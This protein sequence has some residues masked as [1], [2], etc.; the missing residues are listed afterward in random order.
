[1]SRTSAFLSNPNACLLS[2]FKSVFFASTLGLLLA[3]A[4]GPRFL[5]KA[6]EIDPAALYRV[7]S[8]DK[9][10]RI[11]YENDFFTQTDRDYTQGINLEITHPIFRKSQ[12]DF[13][14]LKT[15]GRHYTGISIEL[16]GYTPKNIGV[17]EIQ[18]GDH[19]YA[20][21]LNLRSFHIS[22]DTSRKLRLVSH[23]GF[24]IM[25]PAGGGDEIQTAVHKRFENTLP[26]GWGNQIANEFLLNYGVD[27][28]RPIIAFQP[29]F[30]LT[31]NGSLVLGTPFTRAGLGVTLL[32]GRFQS[33]FS[34]RPPLRG[35]RFFLYYQPQTL[36]FLYD[37]TLQ[38]GLLNP[39]SPYTIS[40]ADIKQIRFQH[41]TG[42]VFE[43]RHF[44]LEG[45]VSQ[46]SSAYLRNKPHAWGGIHLGVGF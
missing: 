42:F 39:T 36:A 40:G 23:F 32:T 20:A 35:V 37:A 18:F 46:Q 15:K 3:I 31:G 6:Q 33:P 45:S 11:S 44:R 10:V 28:Q 14:L 38:G 24:G 2:S 12:L 43:Y 41:T 26:L 34:G 9:S 4:P 25:G 29:G 16:D 17:R 22:E 13:L 5:L 7:R 19:P 30:L 8:L 21:T 1:M 27:L